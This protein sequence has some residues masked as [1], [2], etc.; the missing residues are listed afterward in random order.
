MPDL[1]HAGDAPVPTRGSIVEHRIA[2]RLEAARDGRAEAPHSRLSYAAP[3]TQA[4]LLGCIALRY[5]GEA[6]KFNPE[7][8]LFT[9]KPEANEFLRLRERANWSLA[10]YRDAVGARR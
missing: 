7:T 10:K 6:L 1:R 9:N 8:K 5:P 2:R 4:L 3:F